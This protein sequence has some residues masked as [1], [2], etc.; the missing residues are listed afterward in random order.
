M[1]SRIG[2]SIY[3]V[4]LMAMLSLAGAPLAPTWIVA[5]QK[6]EVHEIKDRLEPQVE[7]TW[8]VIVT[9]RVC[10]TNAVIR[11]F[12]SLVTYAQGG[13]MTETTTA[14]SPT[15][16]GP[17]HGV[18]QRTGEQTYNQVFEAFTFNRWRLDWNAER[19][20]HGRA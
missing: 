8:R 7:S 4:T 20:A 18:W 6:Q 12:P 15:L 14:Q 9:I 2:K 3:G 10:Q 13:T 19:Q 16:R 5:A 11:T 17:G 1:K